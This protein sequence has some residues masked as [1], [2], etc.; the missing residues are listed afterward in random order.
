[1]SL[2]QA[3][4]ETACITLSIVSELFQLAVVRFLPR[5]QILS[6]RH[7]PPLASPEV[8]T[9]TSESRHGGTTAGGAGH[10]AEEDVM[11]SPDV[12]TRVSNGKRNAGTTTIDK[13][14][15]QVCNEDTATIT[16][17]GRDHARRVQDPLE[18]KIATEI[19]REIQRRRPREK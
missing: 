19:I 13:S 12:K 15:T 17:P 5:W 10:H 14:V 4:C 11:M 8:L 18:E 7:H 1:V 6:V 16:D 3:T 2:L 9:A